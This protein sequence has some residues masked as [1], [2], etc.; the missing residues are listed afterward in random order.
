M[1]IRDKNISLVILPFTVSGKNERLHN[2]FVG[3]TEDL[4]V[5]FSKFVGLAVVSQYSTSH[6][7]SISDI[8]EIEKLNADFLI[9]GSVREIKEGLRISIQLIKWEDKSVVFAGQHD[10]TIESI[11]EAQDKMIQQIVSVLQQRIDYNLLSYS[12]KKNTVDLAVYE[13]YL[14]GMDYIKKGSVESDLKARGY[15]ESALSIDEHYAPAYTGLSMSYFNEW[16]CQL[17]D[18]WDISKK[19]AH[20][21]AEKAIEK[22]PN[23][24]VALGVL[25]RTYCYLGEYEKA[26]HFLRKSIRINPNDVSNLLR[27]SFSLMYVGYAN[28]AID[29]FKRA[30]ELHPHHKDDYFAYGATYNFAAGNFE[31][32]IA[33]SKKTKYSSWVDFPAVIAAAYF[34]LEDFDNMWKCWNIFL[35]QYIEKISKDEDIRQE[36][37]I[38]WVLMINPFNKGS[39]L[40]P[41]SAFIS[42]GVKVS[43]VEPKQV[44]KI[45][46]QATFI[47]REDMWEINF[48]G[49]KVILKDA[50]GFHD[51]HKVLLEPKEDFH[52]MDLMGSRLQDNV[53]VKVIDATAKL[54][55]QDRI[56]ELQLEM[57][58][59]EIMNNSTLLLSLREEYEF[60]LDHISSSMGLAGKARKVGSSVEKARSA[61]TWRIRSTIKKIEKSHPDLADHLSRSIKTGTYCSYKPEVSIDWKLI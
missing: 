55:Y 56:R 1:K 38:S 8:N 46:K 31:E 49:K 57:D 28:E 22:D 52:C 54:N 51:I 61:I 37:A 20:D 12:Y 50:K 47:Q 24:Y 17:W 26:E 5:N 16:S 30:I 53:G 7:R 19:G 44:N 3:F 18:R 41:F 58:D 9:V 43:H 11:L 4:I 36:D 45:D 21:Y 39:Y 35:S 32:C 29:I 60:L 48:Q 25:G 42:Q 2:L 14:I 40:D 15:F 13:N 27:V 34:H 33:L 59:A 23:D 10:E 6:I